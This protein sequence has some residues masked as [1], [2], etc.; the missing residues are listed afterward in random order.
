LLE[1]ADAKVAVIIVTWGSG[2]RWNAVM[3]YAHDRLRD[4]W[5]PRAIWNTE[6]REVRVT[7]DKQVA[8]FDIRST[9]GVS[10]FTGNLLAFSSRT[11][12]NW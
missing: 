12:R 1:S 11:N 3:L 10:I 4:L 7:F 2:D 5:A 6:A 9:G 8:K